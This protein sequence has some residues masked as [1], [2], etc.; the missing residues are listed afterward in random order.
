[1]RALTS[2]REGDALRL[3]IEKLVYGG[4]G[5]AHHET[6]ACFVKNVIPGEIVEAR[7]DRIHSHYLRCSALRITEPSPERTVPQC[8]LIDTC[9][10]CQWQHMA[11]GQQLYWKTGILREALNHS[12]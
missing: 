10:G 3:S 5:F 2:I 8:P 12:P 4:D 6:R 1:M 7:V 11:Y 9:G